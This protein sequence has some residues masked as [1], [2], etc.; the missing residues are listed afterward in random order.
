MVLSTWWQHGT[1]KYAL[2]ATVDLRAVVQCRLRMTIKRWYRNLRKCWPLPARYT[3]LDSHWHE[4]IISCRVGVQQPC[5]EV[6]FED[7]SVNADVY[8]GSRALPSLTNFTRNMLEVRVSV[9]KI[10]SAVWS[11][12]AFFYTLKKSS[13]VMIVL[14]LS[15]LLM[16][17][18]LA[19]CGLFPNNKRDFPILHGV[20]GIIRPGR[21]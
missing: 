10:H 19:K 14:W 7:L 21:Y 12:Q 13:T 4:L 1:D 2:S 15:S 9:S 16:Q 8:V 3:W 18:T 20:S 11:S 5:V 17:G 6:R